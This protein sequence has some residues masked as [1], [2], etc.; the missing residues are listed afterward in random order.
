MIIHKD[1]RDFFILNVLYSTSDTMLLHC[2][3]HCIKCIFFLNR[4]TYIFIYSAHI[5]LMQVTLCRMSMLCNQSFM[6]YCFTVNTVAKLTVTVWL[7]PI[8][9]KCRNS[10]FQL[11]KNCWNYLRLLLST[12]YLSITVRKTVLYLKCKI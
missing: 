9:V 8:P 4:S 7:I 5:F 10:L 11:C 2:S 12:Y 3:Y 6:S 1:I